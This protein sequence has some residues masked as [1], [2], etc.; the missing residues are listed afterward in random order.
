MN[1]EANI[2]T[3]PKKI[4]PPRLWKR[5]LGHPFGR[6]EDHI[7]FMN[8]DTVLVL[9]QTFERI[10]QLPRGLPPSN[11]RSVSK[12]VHSGCRNL[13]AVF[14][15]SFIGGETKPSEIIIDDAL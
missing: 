6:D 10:V 13:R 15:I 2:A 4:T 3:N 14:G 5:C 1:Q 9:P 8:L 11:C 7:P 12:S